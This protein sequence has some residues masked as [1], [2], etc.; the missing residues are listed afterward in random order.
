VKL[1]DDIVVSSKH[2]PDYYL[3]IFFRVKLAKQTPPSDGPDPSSST[4]TQS[5]QS[6]VPGPSRPKRK[7]KRTKKNVAPITGAKNKEQEVRVYMMPPIE[8]QD[9]LT[10]EVCTINNL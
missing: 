4:Q 7:P 3:L 1:Q 8:R 10:D 5:P 2:F 6:P 9:A